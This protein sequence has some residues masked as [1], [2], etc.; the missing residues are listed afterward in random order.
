M[1]I[2][3]AAGIIVVP[4]LYSRGLDVFNLPK[5]IAFRAEAILLLAAAVFWATARRRAENL[6]ALQPAAILVA[7]ILAWT[8]I[9]TLTSTNRALSA[10]TLIT[11][12]AAAVIFM[13]TILAAQTTS[14][15]AVDLVM[16]GAC[17][18]S[19]MVILQ[20]LKIWTPF[21]HE[22][23]ATTQ[24][25][26]V[27][28]LG[29]TNF[30]GSYL[31]GPALAAIV[32]AVVASGKR[33]WVYAAVAAL[34]GTG[35][36]LSETRTALVAV[37]VALAVF[38]LRSR[39]GALVALAAAV[40]VAALMLS[41]RTDLGAHMRELTDAVSKRDYETLFSERL[42][43]ALAAVDMIRD[44]PLTGVGPGC[45]RF[46]F[47]RYRLR[48]GEH[49][50]AAW[51]R[52]Y[53]G[54]WSTVH[55]DHLEVAAETGLPGYA[56]FL[57]AIFMGVR[58]SGAPRPPGGLE[59]AFARAMR[60]PLAALILLLC[61]AQFPLELAAPRLALLTLGA[62]CAGWSGGAVAD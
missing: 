51:T 15:V 62:L 16:I 6:R 39:R 17:A 40:I 33:R 61:L 59:W 23:E 9:T 10:D 58:M 50:P 24:Y 5:E 54:Y 31:A 38:A 47:M 60:W 29:N 37:V 14:I 20:E 35:L 30:V 26:S 52:G 25:K 46:N 53:P 12:V 8:A 41:P 48:V 55:N 4:L 57:I 11:V 34:V 43:P 28:L 45:F 3:L 56:L 32:L 49:Y 7:I 36:V 19:I 18:N 27:G 21:V 13:A 42:L 1:K 44:H 2:I 22:A